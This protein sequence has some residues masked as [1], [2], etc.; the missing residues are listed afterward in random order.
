M[1]EKNWTSF[2]LKVNLPIGEILVGRRDIDNREE[3][4]LEKEL[5]LE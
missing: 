1:K 5:F 3:I 2:F 4:F